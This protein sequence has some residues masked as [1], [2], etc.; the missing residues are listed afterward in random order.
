MLRI[1]W[2][3]FD[4]EITTIYE[5]SVDLMIYPEGMWVVINMLTMSM[6]WY[7]TE[8]ETLLFAKDK[9]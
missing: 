5:N 4:L 9:V 2:N 8:Y 6:N 7:R 1:K 3:D